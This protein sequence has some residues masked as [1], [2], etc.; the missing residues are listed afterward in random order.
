MIKVAREQWDGDG[1]K[2]QPASSWASS[3]RKKTAE[4]IKH[5]ADPGFKFAATYKTASVKRA[6]EKLF[7]GKCAYCE[8]RPGAGSAWDVEHFRPKGR[9]AERPDHPGYYWLA[10]DWTN[11]YFSCQMCNQSRTDVRTWDDPASSPEAVGGKLD[12]FPVSPED[13]RKM[14]HNDG[15][16]L[17][18]ERRLLIDPCQD[19]PS[20]HLAFGVLGQVIPRTD[21]GSASARV[22]NLNRRRLK[23]LRQQRLESL[24]SL[25]I[26]EQKLRDELG[27]H[28]LARELRHHLDIHYF[29]DDAEFAGM[30]RQVRDD[31]DAFGLG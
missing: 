2:I 23:K 22:F 12:Q 25:L 15:R 3:A 19:E 31:P 7:H 16:P 21:M 30:C 1:K 8:W 5:H 28:A 26:I 29:A 18:R 13:T 4:A 27:E 10:F 14:A 11:L 24:K 6:L 9:V 17:A 20:Q